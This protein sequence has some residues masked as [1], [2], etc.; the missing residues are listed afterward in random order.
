MV[1]VCLTWGTIKE[2]KSADLAIVVDDLLNERATANAVHDGIASVDVKTGWEG[3]GASIAQEALGK[4]KDGS[5]QHLEMVGKLLS[6]TA[7]AQNGLSE[8]EGAVAGAQAFADS[9]GLLISS[10]G[11]VHDLNPVVGEV[12][13]G[14]AL[15]ERARYLKECASMV[16]QA[17]D[18]ASETDSAYAQ[19]MSAAMN[20]AGKSPNFDDPM[21]GIPDI[22]RKGAGTGEIAKWWYSLSGRQRKV[23]RFYAAK[24]IREGK[25]SKYEF[26]GNVDG[27]DAR[28]RNDI[29]RARLDRDIESLK[30][31][32]NEIYSKTANSVT[33]SGGAA[34]FP[35][36]N[37]V[38]RR[39][40]ETEG[41]RAALDDQKIPKNMDETVEAPEVGLYLY[42][43]PTGEDGHENTHAALAVGNIDDADN[44]TTYV[45]GMTSSVEESAGYVNEMRGL[46]DRAEAEGKGSVAAIAWVG[47]DA[48]PL[49]LGDTS[50]MSTHDAEL[51]GNSLAKHLEGIE[52]SRTASGKPVHQS[53]LGHSYGSTTS[54]YG[55]AQTRPGVV[56]DY[57][58]FGSPGVKVAAEAMHVPEG[59]SFTMLYGDGSGGKGDIIAPVNEIGGFVRG[60]SGALG[61]NPVDPSSGFRV[62]DPGDS[63]A[64]SQFDA[65][66][67][68][69]DEGTQ[70]QSILAKVVAG[71]AG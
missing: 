15:L 9:H 30:K 61:I 35:E 71:T 26:L 21:L 41:I 39:L 4:L 47:Y 25:P 52:D 3:I 42:D 56:D 7:E 37:D 54:S 36:L 46:K 6:A 22:P 1:G 12:V 23:I 11:A 65:H 32:K 24:D 69:L 68:Y 17:C 10:D 70:A 31:K 29:N 45:P 44:V 63:G 64:S 51:G 19:A 55:V 62:M 50:V 66:T 2:W 67:R 43:P 13:S 53:V 33:P 40:K 34:E 8:V 48:P 5:A 60:N 59:H 27:I 14:D 16:S 38:E 57:A 58:V 28:T 20:T 49:P 18:K